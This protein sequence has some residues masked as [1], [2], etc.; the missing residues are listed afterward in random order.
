[1]FKANPAALAGYPPLVAKERVIPQGWRRSP[2]ATGQTRQSIV[3]R[4]PCISLTAKSGYW[5]N[6]RTK[7]A[8]AG[9]GLTGAGGAPTRIWEGIGVTPISRLGTAGCALLWTL[10]TRQ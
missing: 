3:S 6:A 1:M 2:Q 9:C 4:E 8:T 10:P 5:P 7:Y